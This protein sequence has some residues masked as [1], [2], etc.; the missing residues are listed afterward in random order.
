MR[1]DMQMGQSAVVAAVIALA[2]SE[3]QSVSANKAW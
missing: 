1:G 3:D 2:E